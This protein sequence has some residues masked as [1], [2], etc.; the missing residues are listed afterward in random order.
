MKELKLKLTHTAGYLTLPKEDLDLSAYY[1]NLIIVKDS[2]GTIEAKIHSSSNRIDRL[3]SW[4]KS[5][6]TNNGDEILVKFDENELENGKNVIHFDFLNARNCTENYE[7][8][9]SFELETQLEE[10]IA[11]NLNKL[12]TGLK[13]EAKQYIIGANKMDLL[14]TDKNRN[15]VIVEL[16]NRKTSDQ[17]VGQILRYM[18]YIKESKKVEN[19]RGII[20]TP[21]Y[22]QNLEYAVSM[23]PNVSLKYFK[24]NIEFSDT[25]D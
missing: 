25:T 20:V 11:Q 12:E 14:C 19:V 8:H 1:G 23:L 13:L 6:M 7:S 3:T 9:F 22:E 5:R 2:M 4:H 15:Y 10:Y 18:G 21:E 16:K 24:I 17:V